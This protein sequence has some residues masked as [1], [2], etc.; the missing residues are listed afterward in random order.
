MRKIRIAQIGTSEYSHGHPV[1]DTIASR[2]DVFEIVGYALPENEREKF[3]IKRKISA[4]VGG[5]ICTNCW[6]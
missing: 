2:P 4:K 3:E 6:R 5:K 1:F